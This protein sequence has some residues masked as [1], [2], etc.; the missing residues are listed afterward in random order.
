MP[1]LGYPHCF[2]SFLVHF[3][4]VSIVYVGLVAFGLSLFPAMTFASEVKIGEAFV[5]RFSGVKKI[6]DGQGKSSTVLNLDGVVGRLLNIRKPLALPMGQQWKNVPHHIEITARETGQVFG[7]AF[8]D[9][10]PPNIY[11]S[12]TS[13]FG[14]HRSRN[15]TQLVKGVWTQGKWVQGMWGKGGGPGTIYKLNSQNNYAPEIFAHVRLQGRDNSGPALGN[16]AYDKVSKQ[17]FVSDLE[18]GMIHRFDIAT[19]KDLGHYDHGVTGRSRFYDVLTG[20]ISHLETDAFKPECAAQVDTCKTDF[21]TTPSCWNYASGDRRVWG[22]DIRTMPD[23]SRRLF[24]ATWG[25]VDGTDGGN[26]VWSVAIDKNGEFAIDKIAREF[27]LA[28]L[29]VDGKIAFSAPTDLAFSSKGDL[30]IGE[31]GAPR[32]YLGKYESPFARPTISRAFEYRLGLD[33]RWIAVGQYDVGNRAPG[34]NSQFRYDNSAGGVAWGFGY[35]KFGRLDPKAVDK[36][37][38]ISGDSLCSKVGKCYDFIKQNYTDGSHIV[39][40]EGRER[41]FWRGNIDRSF[42]IDSDVPIG[43]KSIADERSIIRNDDSQGAGDVEIYHRF[44]ITEKSVGQNPNGPQN[45]VWAKQ[46]ILPKVKSLPVPKFAVPKHDILPSPV[47]KAP[48]ATALPIPEITRPKDEPLPKPIILAPK[49]LSVPKPVFGSVLEMRKQIKPENVTPEPKVLRKKKPAGKVVKSVVGEQGA[50]KKTHKTHARV[51]AVVKTKKS[52]KQYTQ[53]NGQTKE[54]I[55]KR[56]EQKRVAKVRQAVKG[57]A[58]KKT[59]LTDKKKMAK[60]KKYR[61]LKHKLRK[62]AYVKK[63]VERKRVRHKRRYKKP[64]KSIV[65]K[66]ARITAKC[67]CKCKCVPEKNKLKSLKRVLHPNGKADYRS[68]NKV[69]VFV[70]SKP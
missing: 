59:A 55:K 25:S 6:V 23:G 30:L 15:K 68:A 32:N 58:G 20:K 38:W 51:K 46:I 35:D 26:A 27:V 63:Q 43:N 12:A 69:R 14:L 19:G 29:I 39:G 40:I 3:S 10:S 50:T 42:K 36:F 34:P 61:A 7:I 8:D 65:K 1:R 52:V 4:V 47:I 21:S 54:Q 5:T 64:V 70:P 41:G 66:A 37:V 56:I 16:L 22:L 49:A 24:Y 53:K 9:A 57:K 18:T 60:V 2:K 33:G 11:V 17:L 62:R 44:R 28:P 67:S 48:K 45:G 13:A 31:R